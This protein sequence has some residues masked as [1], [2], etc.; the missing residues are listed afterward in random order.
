MR[1]MPGIDVGARP[2]G[3]DAISEDRDGLR[4]GQGLIDRPDF[5]VGDDE[6]SFWPGLSLVP[7]RQHEARQKDQEPQSAISRIHE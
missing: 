4:H 3:N 2:D 7:F 6:V 5:G 1:S